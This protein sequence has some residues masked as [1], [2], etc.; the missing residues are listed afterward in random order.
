MHWRVLPS[1]WTMPMPN[2]ASAPSSASSSVTICP[3]PSQATEAG[4]CLVWIAFMRATKVDSA[5]GQA[6]GCS[7]PFGAAQQRRGGAVGGPQRRQRLPPLGTGHAQVD[8]VVLGGRQVDRLA[9]LQMHRQPAA[10]GAEAAHH[11]GGLIRPQAIRHPSQAEGAGRQ[12][13]IARQRPVALA[14]QICCA[15]LQPSVDRGAH[16]LGRPALHRLIRRCRP[17]SSRPAPPRRTASAR[18]ARPPR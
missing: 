18:A 2:L 6:T 13:Q 17:A 9:F 10:R 1:P 16:A 11:G 8:R 7:L 4:P 5:S 15:L 14:Q 12:Q 3:V